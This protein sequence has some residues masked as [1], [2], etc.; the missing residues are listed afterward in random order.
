MR[1]GV[2]AANLGQRLFSFAP[3]K[4]LSSLMRRKLRL[5]S[6]PHT[7]CLAR[8]RPSPVLVRMS[9]RSNSAKPAKTAVD[10]D[11]A[12]SERGQPKTLVLLRVVGIADADQ[13]V[14]EKIHDGRQ[15]LPPRKPR[16]AN[17][18]SH[19]LADL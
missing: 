9:S 13:H 6:E 8:S 18:R 19:A 16:R 14:F 17:V 1:N 15:Q 10:V 2:G 5:S 4:R 12:D 3:R 11:M 7:A